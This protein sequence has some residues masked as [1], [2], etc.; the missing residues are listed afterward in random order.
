[1]SASAWRAANERIASAIFIA[2]SALSCFVPKSW[3]GWA[4]RGR[5]SRSS[6]CVNSVGGGRSKRWPSAR[7]AKWGSR[8][9]IASLIAWAAMREEKQRN[10]VASFTS[11][12]T[13]S[14]AST[15][16]RLFASSE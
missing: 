14:R 2:I 11:A 12:I 13:V 7:K 9:S 3:C 15:S 8:S 4:A 6:G 5:A 16:G 10:P 1:M